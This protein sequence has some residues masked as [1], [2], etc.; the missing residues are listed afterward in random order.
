MESPH[1][2]EQEKGVAPI[3]S[4]PVFAREK[5]SWRWTLMEAPVLL[6]SPIVREIAQAEGVESA[7][8]WEPEP[9]QASLPV[10]ESSMWLRRRDAS[11]RRGSL[12]ASVRPARR[13][14]DDFG[15]SVI[16]APVVG[17]QRYPGEAERKLEVVSPRWGVC[18][19]RDRARSSSVD[20][21][22]PRV[23]SRSVPVLESVSE[24]LLELVPDRRIAQ[25]QDAKRLVRSFLS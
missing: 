11:D 9:V 24:S 17:V 6:R 4:V 13:R 2:A 20:W 14:V 19:P 8:V 7:P 12:R 18:V 25:R 21:S 15:S 23:S 1:Q 22:A 10:E 16:F 3:E 5:A